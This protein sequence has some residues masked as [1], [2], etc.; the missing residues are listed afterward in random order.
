LSNHSVKPKVEARSEVK[1]SIKHESKPEAK[2]KTTTPRIPNLAS[3]LPTYKK[4][5][6]NET[7]IKPSTTK[8][9][10]TAK[11]VFVDLTNDISSDDEDETP[12]KKP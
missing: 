10:P 2:P 6:I 8:R 7:P 1:H 9:K 11:R 4:E 3:P 12:T 5:I